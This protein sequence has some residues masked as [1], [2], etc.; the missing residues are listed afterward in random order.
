MCKAHV[1]KLLEKWVRELC[2]HPEVKNNACAVNINFGNFNEVLAAVL[3][4]TKLGGKANQ[5]LFIKVYM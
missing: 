4:A 1:G 5:K 3:E 2:T